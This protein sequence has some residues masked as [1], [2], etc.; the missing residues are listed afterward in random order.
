MRASEE[1]PQGPAV[2]A[3]PPG[4]TLKRLQSCNTHSGTKS[5]HTCAAQ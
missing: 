4:V 1:G 3:G 2:T 5:V